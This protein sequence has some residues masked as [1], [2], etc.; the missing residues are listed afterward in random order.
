M[1]STPSPTRSEFS[2]DTW[3][4]EPLVDAKIRPAVLKSKQPSVRRRAARSLI[5]FCMG[6]AATLAWQSYGDATREMIASAYPQLGWLAP[7]SAFAETAPEKT[8]SNVPVS[9]SDAPE[10][11]SILINVAALRQSVDQL[12]V[13]FL[14]SQQQMASDIAKMKA[15]EQD[16]FDKISSAPP[17]RPA[18][19]PARKPVPVPPPPQ[20]SQTSPVR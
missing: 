14:A 3:P 9:A 5:I 1:T 17:P 7:Q 6:V 19:A 8:S 12:A 11:R 18:A 2:E 10:L 4:T 16:I 13:Q 15:A 20:A